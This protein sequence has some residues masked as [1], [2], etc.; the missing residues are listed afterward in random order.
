VLGAKPG[1]GIVTCLRIGDRVIGNALNFWQLFYNP[2]P[3]NVFPVRETN[4]LD[5]ARTVIGQL[6][7]WLAAD[8]LGQ[9]GQALDQLVFSGFGQVGRD[10]WQSQVSH[11]PQGMTLQ[12][13]RDYLG[14]ENDEQQSE[15]LTGVYERLGEQPPP[16][17][18]LLPQ[19]VRIMTMHGAKGLSARAVFIPALEEQVFPGPRRHPYPGLILEAARL[20]YVSL[21][22][23]R[24]VCI[25]SFATTRVVH[26]QVTHQA[27][28]RFT[29]HLGGTFVHRVG[30]LT[31]GEIGAIAADCA[32]L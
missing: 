25:V 32:A 19:R 2:L 7:G 22:R 28:S 3:P 20:L 31:T 30:G 11:L 1:V 18:Q 27:P 29:A 16:P 10:G 4:A 6:A 5:A 12:E 14:V 8:T 9:R 21:S 13:L 26:G 17:A 24:A 23:A 15:I